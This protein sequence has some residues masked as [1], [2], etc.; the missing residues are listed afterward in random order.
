MSIAKFQ[1]LIRILNYSKIQLLELDPYKIK[2]WCALEMPGVVQEL[3]DLDW[4][5]T[6]IDTWFETVFL[7]TALTWYDKRIGLY[8]TPSIL[9]FNLGSKLIKTRKFKQLRT[10]LNLAA[11]SIVLIDPTIFL[12]AEDL[13]AIYLN[14]D[15]TKGTGSIDYSHYTED[16][17]DLPYKEEWGW[18][19]EEELEWTTIQ[20]KKVKQN[21]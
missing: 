18:L 6:K 3:K 12:T 2:D 10:H 4:D 21:E 5:L 16:E 9:D 1:K 11:H 7:N 19:E 13:D 17:L 8:I 20:V 15:F 14:I